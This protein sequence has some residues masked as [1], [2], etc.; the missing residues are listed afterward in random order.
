[1]RVLLA[2]CLLLIT[3][4]ATGQARR[5]EN[6]IEKE[7][8]ETAHELLVSGMEKDSTDAA[9][10]FVLSTLYLTQ[11][12][13]QANLDSAYYFSVL[14]IN[15]YDQLD[16]KSLDRQIKDGFGKTR[17]VELKEKI[18]HLAYER[19]K[20]GDKEED[21]QQF[22]DQHADASDLDSAIYFRDKRAFQK[23]SA[24]NSRS[25]YKYFLDNYKKA[26]D[27]QEADARYQ[28][29]LYYEMT[30]SGKLKEYVNFIDSYPKSPNFEQSV[31]EIYLIRAGEN[32]TETLLDFVD[33]Y[34]TT[35]AA[36]K[37]IG[38]LYHKHLEKEPASSFADKYPRI[39]LSDSL[40][41]VI[42]YQNKTLIPVWNND[43]I[44]FIDLH[45]NI[46]IDSLTSIEPFDGTTDFISGKK[47]GKQV[48]LGKSGQVFY[49]GIWNLLTNLGD[50]F[51]ALTENNKSI[52]VNENGSHFET[53]TNPQLLGPYIQ[54]ESNGKYGLVSV[55]G[56]PVSS[57]KYDSIWFQNGLIFLKQEEKVSPNLPETFYPALDGNTYKTGAFYEDF[58]WLGDTLL[59]VAGNNKEGLQQ[60]I[61]NPGSF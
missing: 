17:L 35:H 22:M 11:A 6:L 43:L 3:N 38:L 39:Q 8:Y 59:W 7:K 40:R 12:W 31:N 13:P 1:M 15:K 57:A 45:Q 53:G 47:A 52:I 27:W 18:D 42:S 25:S 50:G 28:K 24:L 60:P 5:A 14:A 41:Q 29:I 32:S 23:A 16:E 10:P 54:F 48:L 26:N 37:A 55:T 46:V 51:I 58:E 34:P 2:I 56:K 19:A 20:G 44:R 21:Y 30:G 33:K 36:Q 4:L 9:L 61:G 49:T